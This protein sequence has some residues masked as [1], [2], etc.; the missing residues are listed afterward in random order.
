L[1]G[2]RVV[3]TAGA[4]GIGRAIAHGFHARG[5]KVAVCDISRDFL[6]TLEEE[7]PGV[8]AGQADVSDEVE[9]EAF[10]DHALAQLGGIDVLVNNAGVSGPTGGIETLSLADWKQCTAVNLDGCFLCCRRAVPLMKA[11]SWGVIINIASTAGILAYPM[12]TPYA[13]SKWA[14]VGL[15]KTLAMELGGHGIRV[16]AIAPGSINNDRMDG[17]IAREAK[18]K[19]VSENEIRQSYVRQ[20]AMKTMI[21]PEEI[22]DIALFLASENARHINGQIIAV[23]GYSETLVT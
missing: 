13:A 19:V 5:G 23:D 6:D 4:S 10:F 9:I 11:Q 3:V 17:V 18:A 20:S 8:V 21:D 1:D 16:N 12:R 15:T 14:V 7:L 22:A 2:K